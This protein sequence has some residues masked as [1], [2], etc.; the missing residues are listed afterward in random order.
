MR[1]PLLLLT[2]SLS[3]AALTSRTSASRILV[4]LPGLRHGTAIGAA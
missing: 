3:M 1:V 4:D 2:T